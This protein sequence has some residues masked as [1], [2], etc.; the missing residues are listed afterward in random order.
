MDNVMSLALSYIIWFGVI[1]L[2]SFTEGI[3]W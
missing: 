3:D 1:P 2:V